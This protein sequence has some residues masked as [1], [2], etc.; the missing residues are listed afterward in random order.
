MVAMIT[1]KLCISTI[2]FIMFEGG[3]TYLHFPLALDTAF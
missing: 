2:F 1:F 3:G